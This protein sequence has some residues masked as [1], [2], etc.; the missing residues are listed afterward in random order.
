MGTRSVDQNWLVET[1]TL[2][3]IGTVDEVARIVEVLAGPLR[4]FV[5]GQVLRVEGGTVLDGLKGGRP[6][7]TA[8]LVAR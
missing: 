3:R 8:S 1:G 6:W 4:A 2:D 5:S 7:F